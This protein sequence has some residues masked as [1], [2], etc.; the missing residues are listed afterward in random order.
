MLVGAGC[1]GGNLKTQ[2]VGGSKE[3]NVICTLPG[4][5]NSLIIVGAHFDTVRKTQGAAEEKGLYGS[6]TYVK[7]LGKEGRARTVAMLN[8]D[9]LGLGPTKV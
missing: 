1:D 3:P 9:V 7:K 6:R 4:E 8:L 2:K 5:T